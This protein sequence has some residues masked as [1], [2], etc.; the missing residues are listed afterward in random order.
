ME[1]LQIQLYEIQTPFDAEIVIAEGVHRAGSVVLSEE[2]WQDE[3]LCETVRLLQSQG[4]I[5]SMIPL[6]STPETIFKMLD[7]YK[8]DVVHFCEALT[9]GGRIIDAVNTYVAFQKRLKQLYPQIKIMRAVPIGQQGFGHYVPTLV[10][11]QLF[12]PVSDIFLTDTYLIDHDDTHNEQN[13]N[14]PNKNEPNKNEIDQPVSGF[15]GITG[16]ICDWDVARQLIESTTLPVILAGGL[17]PY[18]VYESILKTIPFGVD[19]CTGTN[20]VNSENK[21]IRFK[22]DREKVRRFVK[23]AKRA[24]SELSL[25]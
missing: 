1:T 2:K 6:F 13:E 10:L 22:K 8:P 14:E 23:E 17:D 3:T 20:G 21:S 7:Y 16:K 15:I 18:N 25:N 12:E 5:S 4:V 11:A 19:S 9:K 24:E